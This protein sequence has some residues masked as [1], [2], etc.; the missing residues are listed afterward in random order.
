VFH[1]ARQSLDDLARTAAAGG[2]NGVVNDDA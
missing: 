2:R 1:Y